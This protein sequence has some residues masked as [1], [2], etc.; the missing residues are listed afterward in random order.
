V[1]A[2]CAVVTKRVP[3]N[4]NLSFGTRSTGSL[5]SLARPARLARSDR[6]RGESEWECG[7]RANGVL[8]ITVYSG[9]GPGIMQERGLFICHSFVNAITGAEVTEQVPINNN[10][11]LGTLQVTI[12]CVFNEYVFAYFL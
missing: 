6:Q 8:L 7:E 11:S 9:W 4:D 2:Q 1:N 10:F 3:I 12:I 5:G